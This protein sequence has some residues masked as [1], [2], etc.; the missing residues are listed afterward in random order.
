LD[1]SAD[2]DRMQGPTVTIWSIIQWGELSQPLFV[3]YFLFT[4]FWSVS[5]SHC[6]EMM[7]FVGQ[8]SLIVAKFRVFFK[9][10]TTKSIVQVSALD[11]IEEMESL[12]LEKAKCVFKCKT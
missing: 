4:S 1:A 3:H 11:F 2:A 9:L 12:L 8:S 10:Q 6:S 7:Y 5:C